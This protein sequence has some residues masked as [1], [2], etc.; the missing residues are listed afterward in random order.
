LAG[1]FRLAP[2]PTGNLIIE[3]GIDIDGRTPTGVANKIVMLDCSATDFY[4]YR[5][6]IQEFDALSSGNNHAAVPLHAGDRE[7]IRIAARRDIR[8]IQFYLPKIADISAGRDI[9]DIL[10][11]GL[12]LNLFDPENPSH[13]D[14]SRIAAGRD[15]FFDTRPGT[16]NNN[17]GILQRGPGRLLVQAAGEIDLGT[18]QGIKGL[19]NFQRPELPVEGGNLYV[20]AGYGGN[21]DTAAIDF[22]FGNIR[23]YGK[24]Y[25]QLL[26]EGKEAE[27]ADQVA[28][29]RD[30]VIAALLEGHSDTVGDGRLNMINSQISAA[31]KYS[32]VYVVSRAAVNV[33]RSTLSQDFQKNSGIYTQLGGDIGLFARG[34]EGVAESGD[35]NINEARVMTFWGGDIVMWSDYGNINAGRGSKTAISKPDTSSG[36]QPPAVGSG[37][38]TLTYD[39]DGPEGPGREPNPGDLYIFAPEGEIDAGEAGI[40]GAN[41]FLGAVTVTNAQNIEVG[42]TGVGVPDTSAAPGLGALSGAGGL[43]DAGNA[44]ESAAVT[45]S[46]Q[47][48]FSKYVE[49]LSKDL[50]PKWIAVEVIGFDEGQ[51]GTLTGEDS[52]ESRP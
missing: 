30:E 43:S 6:T 48:R 29:T 47:Q 38:R 23:D 10:Y 28:K 52:D 42:G 32:G 39:A 40:S 12:N 34:R 9:R 36:F 27:A 41:V 51:A 8:D 4:G 44:A 20:I 13:D 16:S 45:G 50:V 5:G 24:A 35:L 18:S 49:E 14:V 37:I 31:G 11:D 1:T 25:T 7:A 2:A 33:G 21:F 17:F 26:A 19:G 22:F 3:A 46:A 15:I